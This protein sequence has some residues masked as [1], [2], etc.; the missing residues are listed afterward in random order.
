MLKRCYKMTSGRRPS[1]IKDYFV[2]PSGG[3]SPSGSRRLSDPGQHKN[4]LETVLSAKKWDTVKAIFMSDDELADRLWRDIQERLQH[5][6]T[7]KD[8]VR[9]LQVEKIALNNQIAEIEGRDL[10]NADERTKALLTELQAENRKLSD[11]LNHMNHENENLRL[12]LDFALAKPEIAEKGRKSKSQSVGQDDEES[13][14]EEDDEE[15]GEVVPVQNRAKKRKKDLKAKDLD[16]FAWKRRGSPNDPSIVVANQIEKFE[17]HSGVLVIDERVVVS[18]ANICGIP[19]K[20]T[21]KFELDNLDRGERMS[22]LFKI[23]AYILYRDHYK[24]NQTARRWNNIFQD[25][26]VIAIIA[27]WEFPA[28]C[29][30]NQ[31]ERLVL[32]NWITEERDKYKRGEH[33]CFRIFALEL[34]FVRLLTAIKHNIPASIRKNLALLKAPQQNQ[35]PTQDEEDTEEGID[36]EDG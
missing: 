22:K 26:G 11:E 17:N 4:A 24:K 16:E 3:L 10:E 34:P 1:T 31:G 14:D 27:L 29:E 12:Q 20:R 32:Q 19:D 5:Y 9:K 21:F 36:I 28:L 30:M 13:S 2:S 18:L 33:G 8:D 23:M 7:L 25:C 15:E 35:G 6:H